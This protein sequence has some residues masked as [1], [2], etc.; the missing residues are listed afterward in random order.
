VARTVLCHAGLLL[1]VKAQRS[2]IAF[3]AERSRRRS[4]DTQ[5]TGPRRH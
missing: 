3:D 5:R 1:C 2:Q 4:V